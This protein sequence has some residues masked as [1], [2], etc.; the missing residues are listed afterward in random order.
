MVSSCRRPPLEHAIHAVHRERTRRADANDFALY[1]IA[2]LAM[3][4]SEKANMPEQQFKPGDIVSLRS[5]GPRMTVA[6]IDGQS[7]LCEW[8]SDD[9][10]PQSRSFALTS[11][12]L[13][14]RQ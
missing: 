9:Q 1:D 7:A 4:L 5:G 11:L 13:D 8:F 14:D 3:Q 12:K 6:T 2:I 10:Q